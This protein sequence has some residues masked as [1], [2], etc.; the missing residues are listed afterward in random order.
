M[1]DNILMDKSRFLSMR[2]SLQL[3]ELRAMNLPQSLKNT[4][5]FKATFKNSNGKT[6]ATYTAYAQAPVRKRSWLLGNFR[7]ADDASRD[8]QFTNEGKYYVEFSVN[9]QAFDRFDFTIVKHTGRLTANGEWNDLGYLHYDIRHRTPQIV[10]SMYMK[11]MSEAVGT[12]SKNEGQYVAKII[13]QSD[14]K[15]IGK[16]NSHRSLSPRKWWTRNNFIFFDANRPERLTPERLLTQDGKYLVE[17]N[18][19]GKFYGKYP[20]TVKDGKFLGLSHYKG[21]KIGT[22]GTVTWMQR[23]R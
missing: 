23:Q 21:E 10:F 4:R 8:F 20:F 7:G 12:R 17:F 22:D 3:N 13:R 18:Y 5:N 9:N 15:I 2:G 14:G 1:L 16:T 19:E 11:N 6:L